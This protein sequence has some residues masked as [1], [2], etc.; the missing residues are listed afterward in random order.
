MIS[1]K[2]LNNHIDRLT[3][4]AA[5]PKLSHTEES[6]VYAIAH[7]CQDITGPVQLG[8]FY[9]NPA[10]INTLIAALETVVTE[11]AQAQQD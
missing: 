11:Q 2:T 5:Y 4:M 6:E 9:E 8:I 10:E 1:T 3:L 7:Q